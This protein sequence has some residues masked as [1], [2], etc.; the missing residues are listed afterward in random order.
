MTLIPSLK[1][2]KVVYL[3]ESKASLIYIANSKP[4]SGIQVAPVPYTIKL[5]LKNEKE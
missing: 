3:W 2:Q 4:P 1:R 5:I